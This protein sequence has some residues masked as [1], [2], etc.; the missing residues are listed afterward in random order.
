MV[1]FRRAITIRNH[2]IRL[3]KI[4]RV[5]VVPVQKFL[6]LLILLLL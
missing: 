2:L 4:K 6:V 1:Q 3:R 5:I